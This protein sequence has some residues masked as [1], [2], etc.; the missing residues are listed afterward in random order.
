M[1]Y[2]WRADLGGSVMTPSDRGAGEH[3]FI[4]SLRLP[5]RVRLLHL[6]SRKDTVLFLS[7]TLGFG[8]STLDCLGF[9]RFNG[10]A[11]LVRLSS[12]SS[13][14]E[15]LSEEDAELML[16]MVDEV[17]PSLRG[18]HRKY[19]RCKHRCFQYSWR[20]REDEQSM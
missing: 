2:N 19:G 16:S 10:V 18:V 7:R 17:S 1:R 4:H 14:L 20:A 9:L 6:A 12:S 3:F 13:S 11:G 8:F 15:E 5:D